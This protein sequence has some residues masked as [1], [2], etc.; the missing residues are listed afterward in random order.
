MLSGKFREGSNDQGEREREEKQEG[1]MYHATFCH[2]SKTNSQVT[3]RDMVRYVSV[4]LYCNRF[5]VLS[6]ALI[7]IFIQGKAV[8]MKN[9]SEKIKS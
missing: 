1:E 6:L 2:P 3:S 7:I 9:E 5:N 8:H 4:R